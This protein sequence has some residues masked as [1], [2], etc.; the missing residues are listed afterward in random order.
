LAP[1]LLHVLRMKARHTLLL[2]ASTVLTLAVSSAARADVI[3]PAQ[4]ECDGHTIGAACTDPAGIGVCQ[5]SQCAHIDYQ[6]WD[7]DASAGP[8]VAYYDCVLCV[9]PGASDGGSSP[10]DAGHTDMSTPPASGC[11]ASGAGIGGGFGPLLLAALGL[12]ARRAKR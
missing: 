6:H 8:P 2:L 9:V 1:G 7:R 11:S 4:T 5:M 12:L 3:P 10:V